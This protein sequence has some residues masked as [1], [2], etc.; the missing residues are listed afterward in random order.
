MGKKSQPPRTH[1]QDLF[2]IPRRAPMNEYGFVLQPALTPDTSKS[3]KCTLCGTVCKRNRHHSWWPATA[4]NERD[5]QIRSNDPLL[6]DPIDFTVEYGEA[7]RKAAFSI[8]Q[9]ICALWHLQLHLDQKKPHR[10]PRHEYRKLALSQHGRVVDTVN[11]ARQIWDLLTQ[12]A[13]FTLPHLEAETTV[14]ELLAND[15]PKEVIF[16]T[17]GY[18]CLR[19]DLYV[20]PEP[21]IVYDLP[22]YQ[23][24]IAE[25]LDQSL[26]VLDD[27]RHESSF[28][29]WLPDNT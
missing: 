27:P 10:L 20:P 2:I 29:L 8:S 1:E 15:M 14:L 3:G 17:I 18:Y 13:A 11:K 21:P 16:P 24:K 9:P 4:K 22:G 25:V 6:K 28:K 12:R 19:E 26:L 7:L 5:A 23:G